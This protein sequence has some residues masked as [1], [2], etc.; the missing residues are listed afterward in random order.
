M[1]KR[2]TRSCRKRVGYNEWLWTLAEKERERWSHLEESS[3]SAH[4]W[5]KRDKKSVAALRHCSVITKL[6]SVAHLHYLGLGQT[7]SECKRWWGGIITCFYMTASVGAVYIRLRCLCAI[8][9]R[10]LLRAFVTHVIGSPGTSQLL[11]EPASEESAWR[12]QTLQPTQR[13]KR[14]FAYKTRIRRE[15]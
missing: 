3:S 12:K 13:Y 4:T 7:L 15:I 14:A 6:I 9:I 5:E 2:E 11:L 1:E 10:L 8:I